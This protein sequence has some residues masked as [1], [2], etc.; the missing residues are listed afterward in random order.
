[1]SMT[2]VPSRC[3]FPPLSE[4]KRIAAILDKAD[5]LRRKRQQALQLTEQFLRSTFLD[6]FGDPVRNPKSGR[7][8]GSLLC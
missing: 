5:A 6:M 4:Q 3:A 1:M 7:C 2:D 8:I